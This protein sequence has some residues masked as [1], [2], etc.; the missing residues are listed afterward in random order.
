M[1]QQTSKNISDCW[2]TP[3]SFMWFELWLK[4]CSHLDMFVPTRDRSEQRFVPQPNHSNNYAIA[5]RHKQ[6]LNDADTDL[7]DTHTRQYGDGDAYQKQ[8][9]ASKLINSDNKRTSLF[10]SQLKKTLELWFEYAEYISARDTYGM[11]GNWPFIASGYRVRIA[12]K[13]SQR[14]DEDSS[15]TTNPP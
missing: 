4:K 1:A 10:I 12:G 7:K 9:R 8:S 5:H 13:S 11:W 3:V 14:S 6:N 2:E 15:G